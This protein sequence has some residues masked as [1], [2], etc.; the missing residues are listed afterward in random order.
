VAPVAA[1]QVEYS[2]FVLDIEGPASA[3][4]LA[5]CRELGV[6][7]VAAMPL[8]RGMITSTFARGEN[9]GDAKDLRP[10]VM[11][12]FMDAN[13]DKNVRIISQFKALADKKG[14][15][16]SQL[17][18]AWLLKQGDDIIPIPG[19]K[20][21]KYLEENWGA[22]DVHLTDEEEAEIRRFVEAAEVAGHYM[23]PQYES[24]AFTDTAEE[25]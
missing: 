16:T 21:L 5:T 8:G 19:T 1:V 11:P 3:N 2:P 12:R 22:L 9:V 25:V 6:T 24:Y 20:K 7:V 14:C 4:F 10:R 15:T 18:I 13:R 17:A 23:P